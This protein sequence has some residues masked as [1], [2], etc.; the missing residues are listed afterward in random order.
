MVS[1]YACVDKAS[2]DPR[3]IYCETLDN[4]LQLLVV[5]DPKATQSA[6]AMYVGVGSENDPQGK[7][8]LAHF[9][10]HMLFI[11]T[12]EYPEVN[13]LSQYVSDHGGTYNAFTARDHTQYYFSVSP[14]SFLE[15]FNIFSSFFISPLLSEAYVERERNA[16]HAEF[17]M[18]Q[19]E[20][21]WR[22]YYLSAFLANPEHPAN[23]FSIGNLDTLTEE[24]KG[25]L[26]QSLM[27][28]YYAH[29]SSQNMYF[30]AVTPNPTKSV[31][32]V[33]KSRLLQVPNRT[34]LKKEMPHR[35]TK[36]Y[37]SRFIKF[38]TLQDS[39][40]LSIEFIIPNQTENYLRPSVSYIAS[41]IGDEGK[42]SIL[43]NLKQRGF[44]NSL[45][46]GYHEISNLDAV[47]TINIGLTDSGYIHTDEIIS[48]VLAYIDLIQEE[49]VS[50][51]HFH[52]MQKVSYLNYLYYKQTHPILQANQLVTNLSRYPTSMAHKAN[53]ITEVS[54]F[55]ARHIQELLSLMRLDN[56]R[57]W[58]MAPDVEVDEQDSI[59]LAEYAD[60]AM[61]LQQVNQWLSPT[62]FDLT[63]PKKNPY[64]PESISLAST[65]GELVP[66]QVGSVNGIET[67]FLKNHLFSEPKQHLH[68]KLLTAPTESAKDAMLK[69]LL[70]SVLYQAT[71]EDL[72][73][74]NIAGLNWTFNSCID[75]IEIVVSGLGDRQDQVMQKLLDKLASFKLT[76]PDHLFKMSQH[77][78]V[79]NL[80]NTTLM[81]PRS[82]LYSQLS[83]LLVPDGFSYDE[84]L[85]AVKAVS[86]NDLQRYAEKYYNTIS[87]K[88]FHY[89]NLEAQHH[90]DFSRFVLTSEYFNYDPNQLAAVAPGITTAEFV[91]KQKDNALLLYY[92]FENHSDKDQAVAIILSEILAPS[93]FEQLRT[94]EQ[95]GYVVNS[96]YTAIKA[97]PAISFIIQS[98]HMLP[99][100]IHARVSSFLTNEVLSEDSFNTV[101][102][103]ALVKL[104]SPFKTMHEES[105]FYWNLMSDSTYRF[106]SKARLIDA[107][108]AL[109]FSDILNAFQQIKS[110]SARVLKLSTSSEPKQHFSEVKGK[111]GENTISSLESGI[112]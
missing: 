51:E 10:E 92:Q 25:G 101:K 36:Q 74:A 63:L 9:L 105:N 14:D 23:R 22:Q 26:R 93:F 48:A 96:S 64:I 20:D 21:N 102:E 2:T 33:I 88:V 68:V 60:S 86:V 89:G 69:Q 99:D 41:L 91:T 35:I 57:I 44:A 87:T 56:A 17:K 42:G 24:V 111:L 103:A 47:F 109:S 55:D 104:R 76:I 15:G 73:P 3:S 11:G 46:A 32:P 90:I 77:L 85:Q 78:I 75:G 53:Y 58:L 49:G 98:P 52:E 80:N 72:Y 97:W 34:V 1:L 31:L 50:L 45:S 100:D 62:D 107:I 28:F 19:F 40:D 29:Y 84:L 66:K 112:N 79:E 95:I 61:T 30:V 4:G 8:G 65:G 83:K 94:Q 12:E 81:P 59:F 18:H 70:L 7:E 71:I 16:V 5:E 13:A 38:K 110:P 39:R 54:T 67:W 108:N 27:M 37:L 106:D 43:A 82:L 6:A